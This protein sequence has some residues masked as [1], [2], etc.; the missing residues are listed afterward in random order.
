M[1]S[2][3]LFYQLLNSS[4][5]PQYDFNVQHYYHLSVIKSDI[6]SCVST[7]FVRVMFWRMFQT[8]KFSNLNLPLSCCLLRAIRH[9][10]KSKCLIRLKFKN[11]SQRNGFLTNFLF[12]LKIE[13]ATVLWSI[14]KEASNFQVTV[15][16][17][18]QKSVPYC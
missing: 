6:F 1:S 4:T 11:T 12:L 18:F 16:G 15:Y 17:S 13:R 5:Y 7:S 2:S 10:N 14:D 3:L 8:Q 9:I